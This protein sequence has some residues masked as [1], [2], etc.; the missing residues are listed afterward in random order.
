MKAAL[1]VALCM[2]LLSCGT[3]RL[4]SLEI[5]RAANV[6]RL[7]LTLEIREDS[8]LR[9]TGNSKVTELPGVSPSGM[10]VSVKY[11]VRQQRTVG[12]QTLSDVPDWLSNQASALI[13]DAEIKG[14][15]WVEITILDRSVNALWL[16][17]SCLTL[18]LL[19]ILGFPAA[20]QSFE[21]SVTLEV[22]DAAGHILGRYEGT[23][24]TTEYAAAWWGYSGVGA[25]AH[26]F[27]L[28]RAAFFTALRNALQNAVD[29][30]HAEAPKLLTTLDA[31]PTLSE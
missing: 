1:T 9:M 13:T 20:S 2:V 31:S 5:E 30:F 21:V 17:P 23:G 19:N 29:A 8:L 10:N 26:G 24:A 22:V 4:T 11:T 12:S 25:I 16:V 27:S 7:P 18:G 14:S 3:F 15:L 6:T 28:E